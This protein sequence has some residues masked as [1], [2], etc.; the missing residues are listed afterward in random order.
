M[1]LPLPDSLFATGNLNLLRDSCAAALRLAP[2]HT[3]EV[4]DITTASKFSRILSHI[5]GTVSTDPALFG[6]DAIPPVFNAIAHTVDD[7]DQFSSSSERSLMLEMENLERGNNLP[8]TPTKKSRQ[9]PRK[10]QFRAAQW[11]DDDNDGGDDDIMEGVVPTSAPAAVAEQISVLAKKLSLVESVRATVRDNVVRKLYQPTVLR[12]LCSNLAQAGTTAPPSASIVQSLSELIRI[13]SRY[14]ED[15][16]FLDQIYEIVCPVVL[17]SWHSVIKPTLLQNASGTLSD[18]GLQRLC[19]LFCRCYAFALQNIISEEEFYTSGV[20]FTTKDS[21][22]MLLLLR[23][24]PIFR[25]QLFGQS[26]PAGALLEWDALLR[27]LQEM[28]LQLFR[29]Q[30]RRSFTQ[31]QNFFIMSLSAEDIIESVVGIDRHPVL[32][33][34][35]ILIPTAE[36][37]KILH[38]WI[39]NDKVVHQPGPAQA[40]IDEWE[41]EDGGP[42]IPIFQQQLRVQIRRSHVVEDTLAQL[43]SGKSL[44]KKVKVEFI[45]DDGEPEPGVDGGGLFRELFSQVIESGLSLDFGLFTASAERTLLPNPSSLSIAGPD[46]LKLFEAFGKFV[47]KSFYECLLLELPL[48][49]FFVSALLGREPHLSDVVYLDSELATSLFKFTKMSDPEL[50]DFNWTTTTNDASPRVVDLVPNG[51][52]LPVTKENVWSYVRAVAQFKLYGQICDQVDAFARGF[53]EVV[54]SKWSRIFSEDEFLVN[55]TGTTGR[56]NIADLQQNAEFSGGYWE[57]HPTVM[58]LWEVLAEMDDDGHQKFLKFVTSHSRPPLLGF[59]TLTPKF[60]IK[61]PSD[62]FDRLPT[63]NTCMNL[64]KLPPYPTKEMMREKLLYAINA[65]AG[66]ELS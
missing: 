30:W 11:D 3:S 6:V 61:K 54:P 66:F 15:P 34:C 22:E 36:K 48:A 56:I 10:R 40:A 24:I 16:E 18:P 35:P 19:S 26:I 23:K 20:P 2:L 63:S 4:R 60:A 58:M 27:D 37:V 53:R 7:I 49:H 5:V 17:P 29:R 38:H 46:H 51:S 9:G 65:G 47:G 28:W 39:E 12:I 55:I 43:G 42:A 59:K 50:A 14:V 21:T 8:V 64:F 1:S 25:M 31:Y 62:D 33:H 52:N 57:M 44:K 13:A 32:L 45:R 41:N